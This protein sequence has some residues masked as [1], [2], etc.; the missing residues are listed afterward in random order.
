MVSRPSAV[1]PSNPFF[2]F[3][4][5]SGLGQL[6]FRVQAQIQIGSEVYLVTELMDA[7][8]HTVI[9]SDQ[10]LS[11]L[12]WVGGFEAKRQIRDSTVI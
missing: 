7:D 1:K 8:L 6:G 11:A 10:P 5:K 9:C 4:L 12:P 3:Q 2:K